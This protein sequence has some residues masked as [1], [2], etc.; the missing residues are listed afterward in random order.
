MRTNRGQILDLVPVVVGTAF[1]LSHS[2][3]RFHLSAAA[4]AQLPDAPA[5]F[6]AAFAGLSSFKQSVLAPLG[7]L[8][9]ITTFVVLFRHGTGSLGGRLRLLSVAAVLVLSLISAVAIDP[10]ENAILADAASLNAGATTALL[11]RW[12][13]WQSVNF[14]FAVMAAAALVVAHRLPAAAVAS[15][16]PGLL[17][18]RHRT[19]LFLLGA[20][21]LFEGYD[22]FIVALALPYIGKDL[23]ASEGDLGYALSLI[24]VGALLSIFL[25]RIA[26]RHGRRRLLVLSVLAYTLATA[27]TGLSSGLVMFVICQL[28][29]TVFLVAELA[30]AQVVIAEEFPAA[31]RGRGQGLLGAFGALGGGLAAVLFPLLQQTTFGWRG[32]YFVGILPLL[33][34][35]YLSRA[36][37]ETQRWQRFQEAG[38]HRHPGVLDVLR[39]GLR[40]RF[41]VLVVV[42]G[43]ASLIGASAFGFATYRATTTFGWTPARVITTIL[44]GGGLG[45]AGWFIFGRLVDARGRRVIGSL[46]LVGGAGA[47]I[48]Y[49]RTSWLLPSFAAMVFLEAGVT[50]ALNALGTELFP[51]DLRATAKAWITNAGILGSMVGLITVGALSDRLGGAAVVISLLALAPILT[52]PLLFLLPE[53]RG[54]ELEAI[55]PTVGE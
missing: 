44:T 21:T 47:V 31:A 10:L 12:S 20:A 18:A 3:F 6:V 30:L 34:V 54:R 1:V 22:R 40:L 4:V 52:A 45:F 16:T 35:A 26:D 15:R 23:G 41:C 48:A 2:V 29:A 55:A 49:Y 46:S 8:T 11:H 17:S 14:G 13:I 9:A 43:L 33:L 7:F 25:G 32:L 19:L 42:A 51:T 24:R 38:G 53:T 39:P 27:A 50:T 37:P 5:A 28:V 36:L